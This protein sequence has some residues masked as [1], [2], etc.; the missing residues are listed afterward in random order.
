MKSMQ[1]KKEDAAAKNIDDE[2]CVYHYYYSKH[3]VELM[4]KQD[5]YDKIVGQRDLLANEVANMEKN[6]PPSVFMNSFER[7]VT[8]PYGALWV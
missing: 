6:P 4:E 2:V 7:Y 1:D 5:A 3:K 8:L